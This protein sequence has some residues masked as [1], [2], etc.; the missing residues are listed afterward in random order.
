MALLIPTTQLL[1]FSYSNSG[2]SFSTRTQEKMC[3]ATQWEKAVFLGN[4]SSFPQVSTTGRKSLFE[5]RVKRCE[6][7]ASVRSAGKRKLQGRCKE[8]TIRSARC[9]IQVPECFDFTWR[10]SKPNSCNFYK[11]QQT[12]ASSSKFSNF[13]NC[14]FYSVFLPHINYTPFHSLVSLT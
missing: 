8:V 12:I 14:I 3:A 11:A 7:T 13:S 6:S 10:E 1:H 9:Y 5:A 4:T 2:Y